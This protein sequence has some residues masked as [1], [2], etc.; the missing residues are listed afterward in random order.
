MASLATPDQGSFSSSFENVNTSHNDANSPRTDTPTPKRRSGKPRTRSSS[1]KSSSQLDLLPGTP[2]KRTKKSKSRGKRSESP[3][4]DLTLEDAVS[5]DHSGDESP[6]RRATKNSKAHPKSNGSKKTANS[7]PG[8]VSIDGRGNTDTNAD[9]ASDLTDKEDSQAAN[10]FD[11]PSS[12]EMTPQSSQG[13]TV[14]PSET[15]TTLAPLLAHQNPQLLPHVEPGSPNMDLNSSPIKEINPPRPRAQFAR[16]KT[17]AQCPVSVAAHQTDQMCGLFR[18]SAPELSSPMD[19]NNSRMWVKTTH[20]LS[21]QFSTANH[22][23]SNPLFWQPGTII[24]LEPKS[25]DLPQLVDGCVEV[26][27]DGSFDKKFEVYATLY[28]VCR[29]NDANTT[30]DLFSG[31]NSPW[32]ASVEKATGYKPKATTA[33]VHN[34]CQYAKRD[35]QHIESKLYVRKEHPKQEHASF[36]GPIDPAEDGERPTLSP[37]KNNPFESRALT[38]ALKLMAYFLAMPP[39]NV[40]IPVA[41]IKWLYGHACDMIV[42]P[43]ISKSLVSS[44]LGILK[45]SN[46]SAKRRK[47]IFQSYPDAISEKMLFAILNMKN[48]LSASLISERFIA[49]RNLIQNFPAISAKN[50]HHW[51]PG[52]LINLCDLSFALYS[53]VVGTGITALLEAAK[54]YLDNNDICVYT[55]KFIEMPLSTNQKSWVTESVASSTGEHEYL[56]FDY[57]VE[58]LKSLVEG[59]FY[60]YAMDIWVGV[61]LLLGNYDDGIDNWKHIGSWLHVHKMCFNENSLVAKETAISSWKVIVYKICCHDL[62]DA[63]SSLPASMDSPGKNLISPGPKRI[64]KT[65]EILRQK[66]RLL[67]HPFMCITNYEIRKELVDAFHNCFLS[68]LYHLLCHQPKLNAKYL[69]T[70]WDKIIQPVLL[71]FYFKKDHSTG[72]MHQSGLAIMKK[73]LKPSSPLPEKEYSSTRCLSNEPMKISDIVSLHPR[74]VYHRFDKVLPIVSLVLKSRHLSF[75]EKSEGFLCFLDSI[76]YAIKNE[77]QTSDTT[78]DLIDNLPFC[79][80]ALLTDAKVSYTYL[81]RVVLSLNDTFGATKL[82]SM[83]EDTKSVVEPVM[84]R[85]L[86]QLRNDQA[87][88]IIEM[89]YYA[90][91]EKNNLKFLSILD[92]VNRSLGRQDVADFIVESLNN[93]KTIKFSANELV[94]IGKML[95]VITHDFSPIAKKILQQIVLLK[96]EDFEAMIIQIGIVKWSV[97][98]FNFFIG[99]MSDAPY[100]LKQ[101]TIDLIRQ[102]ARDS[103][104]FKDIADYVLFNKFDFEIFH[105]RN[106]IVASVKDSESADCGLANLWCEYVKNFNSD[107]QALDD[108]LLCAFEGGLEVKSLVG[109]RWEELPKLKSAWI[110][111]HGCLPSEMPEEAHSE[112]IPEAMPE[113]NTETNTETN[114]EAVPEAIP[115]NVPD[116][117]PESLSDSNSDSN[118][119]SISEVSSQE[120]IHQVAASAQDQKDLARASELPITSDVQTG[121]DLIRSIQ[122]WSQNE[123]SDVVEVS[124]QSQEQANHKDGQQKPTE[125]T[126]R[127]TVSESWPKI[128]EGD[129]NTHGKSTESNDSLNP[130]KNSEAKSTR[131]NRKRKRS[132]SNVTESKRLRQENDP[133][134]TKDGCVHQESTP[135]DMKQVSDSE[136]RGRE[137][138]HKENANQ[139]I[140]VTSSS[141]E[142]EK[143]GQDTESGEMEVHSQSFASSIADESVQLV[144]I[145]PATERSPGSRALVPVQEGSS[146]GH[147]QPSTNVK[148]TA[149]HDAFQ[150]FDDVDLASLN[151][152]ER[153]NLETDMLQFILRMRRAVPSES[154]T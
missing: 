24:Q 64:A 130:N 73:L 135:G 118:S 136:E 32:L 50:F 129:T 87:R 116:S 38:Q 81:N 111:K 88:S 26:L 37:V 144:K 117:I 76:K 140:E 77:V 52:L 107:L 65:E 142:K 60:K 101:A 105:L 13:T 3:V 96:T 91:G 72:L 8:P 36:D 56:A 115:V 137:D 145:P 92:D 20:N 131:T 40:L 121:L 106:E 83:T 66:I 113:A 133:Q 11:G 44:Y 67:I 132:E 127:D 39:L 25:N 114:T 43:T 41:D 108:L 78:F 29:T 79:L 35:M 59:G 109:D 102:R 54:N 70:I 82:V 15:H 57:V 93:K 22:S 55:R 94:M 100:H 74:W 19:P 124:P 125:K 71:S 150:Q 42:K 86:P 4:I 48:Y 149:I 2:R 31:E 90:I 153:Y 119:D 46:F 53:K 95:Q 69:Q 28:L 126:Q 99:L 110:S 6:L 30:V 148:A 10:T 154:D 33:H 21:H 139:G 12:M 146:S 34:L 138:E 104:D 1:L 128:E 62:K 7:G 103:R 112:S 120:S 122:S 63:R 27:S 47:H 18:Y 123:H 98:I 5:A 58:S 84:A 68:I 23:P 17:H 51:F 152:R 80:E 49:L 75:D 45:D 9:H 61:T 134:N 151:E 141:E 16:G 89:W 85:G 97:P 147:V 14:T 143:S